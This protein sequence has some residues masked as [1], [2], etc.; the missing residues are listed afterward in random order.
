MNDVAIYLSGSI[1]KGNSDTRESFWTDRD[2]DVIRDSLQPLEVHFLNPASRSDDLADFMGT[3][4]RDLF[5]V[6]AADAILVDVRDRRGI[7]VGSEMTVAKAVGVPVVSL[8]PENT[9]YRRRDFRFL[10][11]ELAEWTHPFVYGLSD[12]IVDTLQDACD[13]LATHRVAD[14]A[15]PK[16]L[17]HSGKTVDAAIRHYLNAQLGRDIEMQSIVAASPR[18]EEKSRLWAAAVDEE[19][20]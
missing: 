7:G 20:E 14:R 9:H 1:K 16:S 6:A 3:F 19:T 2:I 15:I 13:W 8:C 11:Q 4:G 17:H 12:V 18:L 5:Q 10:D